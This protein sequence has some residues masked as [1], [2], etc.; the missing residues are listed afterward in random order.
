M[1]RQGYDLDPVRW[2]ARGWRATFFVTGMEHS[3]TSTSGSTFEPTPWEAIQRPAARTLD[4]IERSQ[5]L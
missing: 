2:D 5:P 3:M 4:R 1:Q